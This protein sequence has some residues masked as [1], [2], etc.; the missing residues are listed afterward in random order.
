MKTKQGREKKEERGGGE[1]EVKATEVPPRPP[2]FHPP[3]EENRKR[4]IKREGE[5]E[6]N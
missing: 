3:R 4:E 5:K 1:G 6:M 2:G